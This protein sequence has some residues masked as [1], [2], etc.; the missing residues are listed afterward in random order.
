MSGHEAA[1]GGGGGA[2]LT[3]KLRSRHVATVQAFQKSVRDAC[4]QFDV[5]ALN[6]LTD[7]RTSLAVSRSQ[8]EDLIG[9]LELKVSA[10]REAVTKDATA[11]A[12]RQVGE[13][14]TPITDGF[15]ADGVHS[16]DTREERIAAERAAVL[17]MYVRLR[18]LHGER[19]ELL[20]ATSHLL[21]QLE[22]SRRLK[23][24]GLMETL[25]HDLSTIA[26]LGVTECHV[27]VQRAIAS[28]NEQLVANQRSCKTLISQ[29]KQHELLK[30]RDYAERTAVLF[31]SLLQL[32]QDSAILWTQQFLASASFRDPHSRTS[33]LRRIQLASAATKGEVTHALQGMQS[34]AE[35][36]KRHRSSAMLETC[37]GTEP[38]GWLRFFN[39]DI[40]KPIFAEPPSVV[41]DEWRVFLEVILHNAQC[42]AVTLS[43]DTETIE[44]QLVAEMARMCDV[45]AQTIEFIYS[46]KDEE[47]EWV[48]QGSLDGNNLYPFQNFV[49][50]DVRSIEEG[51]CAASEA[52]QPLCGEIHEEST[53]FKKIVAQSLALNK[54]QLDDA[55]MRNPGN[56]TSTFEDATSA[57]TA[58]TE[59]PMRHIRSFY[60]VQ[61]EAEKDY[62]DQLSW[63]ERDVADITTRLEHAGTIETAK[64]LCIEGMQKLEDIERLYVRYHKQRVGPMPV[65]T[66]DTQKILDAESKEL[67]NK[68]NVI[69]RVD[70]SATPQ[71]GES[72]GKAAKRSASKLSSS[73]LQS[74][75]AVTLLEPG[76]QSITLSD[77]TE[78]IVLGPIKF[79][80]DVAHRTAAT[81]DDSV[82]G[83]ASATASATTPRDK[84]AS[85]PAPKAKKGPSAAEAEV[86]VAAE[87]VAQAAVSNRP[88]PAL[89][90][91]M[92]RLEPILSEVFCEGCLYSETSID[93]FKSSVRRNILEWSLQLRVRVLDS[94]Q[95]YCFDHKKALDK[96][97]NECV[98]RHQRRPPTLQAQVYETRIR[99]LHDG[100]VSRA[101]YFEWLA[102]R[103]S[104]LQANAA[105]HQ[106]RCREE[107]TKDVARLQDTV[108]TVTA[109]MS[110]AAL[111]GHGRS[112]T[113]ATRQALLKIQQRNDE[114]KKQTQHMIASVLQECTAFRNERLKSFDDGGS[115]AKEEVLAAADNI[116]RTIAEGEEAAAQVVKDLDAL[117]MEQ[118]AT[119]EA[120][121]AAYGEQKARNND[122]LDFF[123]RIQEVLAQL[124]GRVSNQ[125]SL[126]SNAQR[127]IDE[128]LQEL[129]DL[130]ASS[131]ARVDAS[132]LERTYLVT[133]YTA[134]YDE[135]RQQIRDV[136]IGESWQGYHEGLSNRLISTQLTASARVRQSLPNKLLALLDKLRLALYLRGLF[137]GCLAYN[138]EY[139]AVASDSLLEP[140]R[141]PEI[142]A[143]AA[144]GN[145]ATGQAA[146]AAA[147][148]KGAPPKGA[149]SAPSKGEAAAAAAAAAPTAPAAVPVVMRA[150][151]EVTKWA[152]ACQADLQT[153][154][155]Q[156]FQK[157]PP[158]LLRPQVLNATTPEEV[159]ATTTARIT[160]QQEKCSAHI[161]EATK[162]YREQVQ[163]LFIA[164][165]NCGSVLCNGLFNLSVGSLTMRFDD[166]FRVFNKYYSEMSYAK[167]QNSAHIKGS[168]AHPANRPQ[169]DALNQ[170]ES[171]R[172]EECRRLLQAFEQICL[173]E[174]QDEAGRVASRVCHST[175]TLFTLLRG[176]VTP[177]HIVPGEGVVLGQHKGLKR[178]MR[179]RMREEA[180]KQLESTAAAS[181]SGGKGGAAAAAK[182]PEA[183]KPAEKPSGK[184][185]KGGKGDSAVGAAKEDDDAAAG[186]VP[187]EKTMT[188]YPGIVTNAVRLFLQYRMDHSALEAPPNHYVRPA[189]WEAERQAAKQQEADQQQAAAEQSK[190][191]Q[192]KAAAPKPSGSKGGAQSPTQGATTTTPL[193]EDEVCPTLTAPRDRLHQQAVLLRQSSID[194]FSTLTSKMGGESRKKFAALLQLENSWNASWTDAIDSLRSELKQ[195]QQQKQ[196]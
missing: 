162:R 144:N 187:L 105:Q 161:A 50:A 108:G 49:H 52:L 37:G 94:V 68:L 47:V 10:G 157:R 106:Q 62:T 113:E 188:D 194:A 60:V 115:M 132:T 1:A 164:L 12:K 101:K 135:L 110:S 181:P 61:Y 92:A 23:L 44:G 117:S 151:V 57:L 119:L 79:G 175:T 58:A 156:Y 124:K 82:A 59:A 27:L 38:N 195:Q 189:Q 93:A 185:G 39:D 48:R 134:A 9:T 155:Q 160:E 53:W 171:A 138:V 137:L 22:G 141:R 54:S 36:L 196:R 72:T 17:Q 3:E 4:Q 180:A 7:L 133:D 167:A 146:D 165:H 64:A 174:L 76:Q 145:G 13:A 86:E 77:G 74:S 67:F 55:L 95:T 85:K 65:A 90:W 24:Q 69:P 18:V 170:S 96:Q 190:K 177:E 43:E 88:S 148:K 128:M 40:F 121:K 11:F 158:P 97:M 139:V 176:I 31:G 89:Q 56:V 179:Q 83:S 114:G 154:T 168:L 29:L 34:L 78:M 131:P 126:S 116:S 14:V 20:E 107:F 112:V 193:V 120:I 163:R 172:Q 182:K 28:V 91:F 6:A 102:S 66:A 125:V 153:V 130:I 147:G 19:M 21:V 186:L 118:S 5:E 30:Q 41:A 136:E 159:H 71:P 129:D 98:R 169:L 84:G 45:L 111:E 122:E 192:A 26:H 104:T 81:V 183:K 178:L 142:A 73:M 152:A 8:G 149:K 16:P 184:G 143:S 15:H 33:M 150:E 80:M 140:P 42:S 103:V 109:P 123:V 63:L 173:R 100:N 75:S 46:P 127:S 87:A 70:A 51:K 166:V 2:T 32:A 191:P 35:T 99:E 25:M